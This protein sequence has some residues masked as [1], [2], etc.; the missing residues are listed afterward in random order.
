DIWD[1]VDPQRVVGRQ[2]RD[3]TRDQIHAR[4]SVAALECASAC[5]P[6]P[7][8]SVASDGPCRVVGR[9]KLDS[10]TVGLLQVVADNLLVFGRP[11]ARGTL[12]PAT[13]ALVHLGP[14]LLWYRPI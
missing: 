11:L 3:R 1:E 2:Q 8:R 4:G 7:H 12:E 5:R 14:S 9:A 13:E 6:Q 10:V